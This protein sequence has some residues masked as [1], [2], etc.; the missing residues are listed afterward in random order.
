MCAMEK[1]EIVKDLL[2]HLIAA[3]S[4]L[5]RGGRKA[6][7]SDKMFAAMLSDYKKSIA[8]GRKFLKELDPSA[9]NR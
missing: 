2:V 4:L 3:T 8:R 1:R 9:E 6:A 5:E 7:A